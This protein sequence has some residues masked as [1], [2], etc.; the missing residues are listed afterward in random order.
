MSLLHEAHAFNPIHPGQTYVSQNHIWT[1]GRNFVER[2][3]HRSKAADTTEAL[4]AINQ[5]PQAVT[6]RVHVFDDGDLE[7]FFRERFTILLTDTSLNQ[8]GWPRWQPSKWVHAK[9][10]H[11]YVV[12]IN[13]GSPSIRAQ[14]NGND[15]AA[16]LDVPSCRRHCL[17]LS[18]AHRLV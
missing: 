16:L 10:P 4:R 5:H 2:L 3:L 17:S 11:K 13:S 7:V 6:Q 1:I 18:G 9:T 14:T 15:L 12:T 8:Q